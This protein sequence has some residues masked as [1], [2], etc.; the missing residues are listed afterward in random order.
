MS[1]C[2]WASVAP[3]SA[4]PKPPNSRVPS[5]TV[6]SLLRRSPWEIWCSCSVRSDSHTRV[7]GVASA[8]S[9][10]GAPCGGLVRV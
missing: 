1:D 4:L 3:N 7:T 10:I 9:L 6:I 2:S 8:Q 5:S